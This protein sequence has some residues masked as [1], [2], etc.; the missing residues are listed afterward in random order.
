MSELEM[1]GGG[2]VAGDAAGMAAGAG[3]GGM[4][5]AGLGEGTLLGAGSAG[6]SG[7]VGAVGSSAEDAVRQAQDKESQDQQAAE[8]ARQN[9][10]QDFVRNQQ[11]QHS[12]EVQQWRRMTADDPE[13]GGGRLA[14]S[15][16]R[17]QWALSRFDPDRQLGQWMEES[18]LGNHPEVIRFF[19]RI[20]D[21]VGEDVV[22]D[23]RVAREMPSL[24]ERMYPNWKV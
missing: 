24:E 16:A 3:A 12:Q 4:A 14:V 11:A 23:G 17:A 1:A 10:W 15:V 21:A 6:G 22:L 9:H 8:A 5:G 20:A 7:A 19:N 2:A 18:G 13:I